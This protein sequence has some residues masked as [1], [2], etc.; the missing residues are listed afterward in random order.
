MREV[1]DTYLVLNEKETSIL[2]TDKVN[3][4]EISS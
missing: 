2:S 1:G 4:F 3:S